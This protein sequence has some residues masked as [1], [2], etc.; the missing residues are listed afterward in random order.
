M[1]KRSVCRAGKQRVGGSIP[2]GDLYFPREFFA[3]PFLT[4]G[5]ALANEIKYDDSQVVIVVLD[6]DTINHTRPVYTYSLEPF[7]SRF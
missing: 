1:T 2:F 6:P 3:C 7:K 5:G 4:L